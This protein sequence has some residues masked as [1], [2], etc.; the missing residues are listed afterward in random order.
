MRNRLSFLAAFASLLAA[1]SALGQIEVRMEPEARTYV[2]HSPVNVKVT[3]INRS[4]NAISLRGPSAGTSWLNFKITNHKGDLVTTRPGAPIAGAV[5]V[6]ASR[7][8]SLKVNLNLAYPLDRFGNYQV[9]ANVYNPATR[10]FRSSP[11]KMITIDEAKAIWQQT[12]GLSNGAKNEYALLSYRGYDR[13]YLYFRL[14]NAKNG[15]VKKTYKLG[16][17]VLYRPPQAVVD[18]SRQFHVLYQAA[19]RQYVHDRI[20]SDGKF[21]K[22]TMYDEG[23]GSRPELVQGQDGSVRV[24]GG[25]DPSEEKRK[26]RSKLKELTRIRRLSDR[27]PGY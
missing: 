22:R 26:K 25:V 9:T 20:G 23:K 21:L 1:F 15:Y 16:E 10:R 4:P 7:S 24:S 17:M 2:A 6:G 11:P 18:Q 19:P 27:P 3:V 5:S 14:T 12:V 8:V 13:T